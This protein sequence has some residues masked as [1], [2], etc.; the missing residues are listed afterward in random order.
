MLNRTPPSNTSNVLNSYRK[1]RQQR[2][3]FLVYGAIALVVI[4]VILLIV[5]LMGPSQPLS[6]LFPTETPTPTLTFTPTNTPIPTNTPT[7]TL[8]PTETVAPTPS[9]PFPYTVQEGQ[10]ENLTTISEKFAL[11]ADGVALILLI[12]PYT[13][14]AANF[15]INPLTQIVYPNQEILIPNP[16]MELPTATPLPPDLPRGTKIEYTVQA[17]DTVAGIAAR[18][19]SKTEDIVALNKL[20]N[21][22]AL[23][24]GQVLQIP[25]NLVTVTAT[26]P[27]TSTPVTPTIEGQPSPTATTT[28]SGSAACDFTE[29]NTLVTELGSLINNARTSSGLPALTLNNQ[30]TAAAKAHAVD[31]L[32]TNLLRHEGSDGSTPQSRVTA[33]GFTASLVVE[34]IYA[35]QGG[36]PQSAFN[37]WNNDPAHKADLLN[38]NT[39]VFGIAYVLSNQS[40]LGGYFVVVSAKP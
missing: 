39:T 34:D 5:W 19:N 36:A 12:N 28:A 26:L 29:N 15:S 7:I 8:S 2:G 6:G 17:G 33:Q 25:V 10:N 4:G 37:W 31:L 16:G 21:E 38:P 1:R 35:A 32:C 40:M 9:E 13:E 23:N 30:L 22:N 24:I 18:F 14:D 20:E 11:G 3:P 27:P